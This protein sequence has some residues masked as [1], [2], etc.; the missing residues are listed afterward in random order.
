MLSS[1]VQ[2][3]KGALSLS[4]EINDPRAILTCG[5]KTTISWSDSYFDNEF[6]PIKEHF[7]EKLENLIK[8]TL[9][10]PKLIQS[11]FHRD[12]NLPMALA[13]D[14]DIITLLFLQE[15]ENFVFPNEM[16]KFLL[17]VMYINNYKLVVSSVLNFLHET[18]YFYLMTVWKKHYNFS[19]LLLF[20]KTFILKHLPPGLQDIGVVTDN[21]DFLVIELPRDAQLKKTDFE[22]TW[23]PRKISEKTLPEL[24]LSY[25]DNERSKFIVDLS[26]VQGSF[27]LTNADVKNIDFSCTQL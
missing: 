1:E 6:I 10:I 20:S 17:E 15:T 7:A 13:G 11:W 22:N 19:D 14:S 21:G 5:S 16:K 4:L 26:L 23:K 8:T 3:I 9:S 12:D 18:Q 27:F 24:L 2:K 25:K